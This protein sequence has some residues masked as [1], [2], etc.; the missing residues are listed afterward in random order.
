M[1]QQP[2]NGS[3]SGP[4][5]S[6]FT[7]NFVLLGF[8]YFVDPGVSQMLDAAGDLCQRWRARSLSMCQI[9]D[10]DGFPE[11]CPAAEVL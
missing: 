5:F 8:A 10:G 2:L 3:S 7:R 1:V 9:R 4:L 6:A 11:R